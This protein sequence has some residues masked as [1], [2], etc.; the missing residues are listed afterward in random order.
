[1]SLDPDF[2]PSSLNHCAVLSADSLALGEIN[3]SIPRPEIGQW[4]AVIWENE[5]ILVF[6]FP[7]GAGSIT[8]VVHM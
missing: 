2:T 4:G 3:G 8:N 1:M 7:K 6:V 5:I